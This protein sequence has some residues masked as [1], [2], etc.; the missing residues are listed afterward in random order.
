MVA[1]V[2]WSIGFVRGD[3]S[4]VVRSARV[5]RWRDRFV[6]VVHER[7][8]K[9][10]EFPRLIGNPRNLTLSA[11]AISTV[12]KDGRLSVRWQR[13]TEDDVV[14]YVGETNDNQGSMEQEWQTYLFLGVGFGACK[15]MSAGTFAQA[16]SPDAVRPCPCR[17]E[18]SYCG[19]SSN[20][21]SGQPSV[22]NK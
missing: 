5:G 19:S 17:A 6:P 16:F 22:S 7:E 12:A 1:S 4:S 20:A 21:Y 2:I 14:V 13:G 8:T 15:A 18:E 11:N 9:S 10:H 3:F